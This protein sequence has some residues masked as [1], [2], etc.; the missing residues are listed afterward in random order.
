[1]PRRMPRFDLGLLA[2]AQ[3]A[4]AIARA[5]ELSRLRGTLE[6]KREWGDARLE[7]LYELAFLRVFAAWEQC[8][9]SVFYRSLCVYVST[10]A[11]VPETV[12]GVGR[13]PNVAAAEHAALAG[14]QYLLW[15]APGKV[16]A[17]CQRFIRTGPRVQEN[18]L[19]SNLT[20]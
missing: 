5:G 15:H 7:A 9:E 4:I 19:N 12:V 10:A 6:I 1:M 14:G 2:Q 20:R 17:R 18:V 11:S 13:Y 8:L 3:S 16:I